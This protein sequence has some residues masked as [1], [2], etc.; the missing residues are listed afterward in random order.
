MRNSVLR[1]PDEEREAH[2]PSNAELHSYGMGLVR[3]PDIVGQLNRARSPVL[4]CTGEPG[5]VI[6]VGAAGEIARARPEGLA[7]LGIIAGA[8]HFTWMDAPDRYWPVVTGFLRPV[9]AP[10]AAD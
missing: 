9:T 8:G 4:V 1:L 7:R 3:Q 2:T 5:P 6:A 10:A